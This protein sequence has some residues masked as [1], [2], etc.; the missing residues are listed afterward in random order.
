MEREPTQGL[1][2]KADLVLKSGPIT[3]FLNSVNSLGFNFVICEN[4]KTSAVRGC[5][6]GLGGTKV[7]A[8]TQE[9][10]A[11]GQYAACLCSLNCLL[12]GREQRFYHFTTSLCCVCRW[13]GAV[14]KG[15]SHVCEDCASVSLTIFKV[16]C[17]YFIDLVILLIYSHA[18]PDT[19]VYW[20]FSIPVHV[21]TYIINSLLVWFDYHCPVSPHFFF[22]FMAGSEGGAKS[23]HSFT[24]TLSPFCITVFDSASSPTFLRGPPLVSLPWKKMWAGRQSRKLKEG[25]NMGTWLLHRLLPASLTFKLCMNLFQQLQERAEELCFPWREWTIT[26]LKIKGDLEIVRLLL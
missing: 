2:S 23:H 9:E 3:F 24:T 19:S 5:C 7:C 8:S 11:C 15:K 21:D 1:W 4:K 16:F 6:A 13:E 17:F 10:T 22:S 25:R 12:L 18:S 14:C 26:R 20:S